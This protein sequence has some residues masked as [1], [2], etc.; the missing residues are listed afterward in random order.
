MSDKL[1]NKKLTTRR[2]GSLAVL[3][4]DI[5][6]SK[7]NQYHLHSEHDLFQFGV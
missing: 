6:T 5:V 2:T 7:V 4:Q 1:E 3:W